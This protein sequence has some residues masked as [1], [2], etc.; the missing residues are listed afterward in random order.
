M[1][2]VITPIQHST[3][4]PSQ[5]NQSRKRNKTFRIGKEGVK[6]SL[7]A[8]DIILYR[9]NPKEYTEKLLDVMLLDIKLTYKNQ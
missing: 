2:T 8:H 3:R 5:S 6:L 1:P 7:F 4:S 9:E